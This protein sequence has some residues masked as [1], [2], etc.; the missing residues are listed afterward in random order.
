MGT[1]GKRSTHQNNWKKRKNCRCREKEKMIPIFRLIIC[2]STN[3]LTTFL[4][5]KAYLRKD[6][7]IDFVL[8]YKFVK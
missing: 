6:N 8:K 3:Y 5:L 2:H 7:Q 1:Q 4:P